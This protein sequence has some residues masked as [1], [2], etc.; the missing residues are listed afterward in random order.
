MYH[1]SAASL[2][3][4]HAFQHTNSTQGAFRTLFARFVNPQHASHEPRPLTTPKQIPHDLQDNYCT[5]R[6]IRSKNPTTTRAST[7]HPLLSTTFTTHSQY[8]QDPQNP[9]HLPPPTPPMLFTQ[10]S[11]V[12][13]NTKLDVAMLS[14]I[15]VS[16]LDSYHDNSLRGL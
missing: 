14:N 6:L 8:L 13:H 2:H 9:P 15:P 12:S 4:S 3:S 7:T 11:S 5:Q 10:V 16:Y 1:S